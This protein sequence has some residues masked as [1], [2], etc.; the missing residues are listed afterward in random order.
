MLFLLGE[1]FSRKPFIDML[2]RLEKLELLDKQEWMNLRT[3]RND[4]AH[5]YSF[6]VDELVDSLNDIF[7]VKDKLISFYDTFY[8]Y[9]VV[10]FKFTR[11]SEVLR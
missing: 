3:I 1:D 10:K 9:C 6:N 11:D 2:N 4:V 7:A 5:E 8:G